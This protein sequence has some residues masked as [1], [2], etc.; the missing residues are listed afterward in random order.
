MAEILEL[1][2][3]PISYYGGKQ[4]LAKKILEMTPPH[5]TYCEAFAGGLAILWAKE[6]S[7]QEAI[8]DT[9]K[10]VVNFWQVCQN[11]KEYELLKEKI[12]TTLNSRDIHSLAKNIYKNGEKSNKI[13]RA[14]AFWVVTNFSFNNSIEG[15]WKF[16]K[17]TNK[18]NRGLH[19]L[20]KID[21]FENYIFERLKQVQIDNVDALR[22]V[23][24]WDTKD[25]FFYLDPP[26]P[27]ANQGHYKG[28]SMKDFLELVKML[29]NIKGK[30][31]LSSY[32]YPEL[33]KIAK[34]NNWQ[35]IK[36]KMPLSSSNTQKTSM[37]GIKTEVLTFN[38]SLP[39][40]S[41]KPTKTTKKNNLR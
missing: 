11:K 35:Q 8:N 19:F 41:I 23:K 9:N 16:E 15:S 24:N 3:T 6:K 33:T 17:G 2:K 12:K 38:Y 31:L 34:K 5:F 36:I 29:Q 14:W 22:F 18:R 20:N 32:D 28:Y 40:K 13:D 7:V 27:N 39:Q 1:K 4:Q 21:R 25:T 26:Y 30:F 37:Q 10:E